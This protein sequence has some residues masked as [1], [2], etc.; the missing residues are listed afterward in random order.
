LNPIFV[1]AQ[2]ESRIVTASHESWNVDGS[3]KECFGLP[4]PLDFPYYNLENDDELAV[5]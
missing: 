5:G 3:L 2:S 1:P 4:E